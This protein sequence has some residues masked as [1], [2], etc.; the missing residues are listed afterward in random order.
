VSGVPHAFPSIL[1]PN[2]M[3]TSPLL[4]E[5]RDDPAS[6]GYRALHTAGGCPAVFD[7]LRA[8]RAGCMRIEPRVPK[9][10]A[11]GYLTATG[12]LAKIYRAALA[13]GGSP[14]EGELLI[15]SICL[16][17]WLV[18][19]DAS[20]SVFDLGEPGALPAI[21]ALVTAGMVTAPQRAGFLALQ[22]VPASRALAISEGEVSLNDIVVATKEL[23]WMA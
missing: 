13:T 11:L 18:L 19:S 15:Q 5:L 6:V 17:I 22:Q 1:I 14:S 3:S 8:E 12:L 9:A 2:D 7:A 4:Q 20:Y 16:R 21:D 10:A 23:G